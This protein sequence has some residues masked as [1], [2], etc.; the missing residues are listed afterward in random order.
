[1]AKHSYF[2]SRQVAD[3]WSCHRTS[4]PRICRRFGVSGAKF[5][6]SK[7]SPRRFLVNDIEKVE[8]LAAVGKQEGA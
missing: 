5:G 2:T 6:S 8:R 1:M 7:S 3:R 4:V